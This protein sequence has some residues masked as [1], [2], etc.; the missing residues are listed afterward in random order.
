MISKDS[1]TIEARNHYFEWVKAHGAIDFGRVYTVNL[2]VSAFLR[3][4]FYSSLC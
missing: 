1:K 4:K 2:V 3:E